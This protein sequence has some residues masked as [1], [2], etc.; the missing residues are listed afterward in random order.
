HSF[1][2]EVALRQLDGTANF[3]SPRYNVAGV[4][5]VDA[6]LLGVSPGKDTLLAL[7]QCD[8]LGDQTTTDLS[9]IY[10]D[11][12][13]FLSV[14]DTTSSWAAANGV[15]LRTVGNDNDCLYWPNNPGCYDAGLT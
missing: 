9:T 8:P 1:G 7:F 6:P 5:T 11:Q 14:Y 12:S 15:G 3:G 4:V 13:L 2:G 10:E